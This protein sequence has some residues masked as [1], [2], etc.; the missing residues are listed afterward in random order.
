MKNY[1]E[2]IKTATNT[3]RTPNFIITQ[4]IKIT[5][6][7]NENNEVISSDTFYRRNKWR[8]KQYEYLFRNR[9]SINGKRMQCTMHS[10]IFV[11]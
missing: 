8:D 5:S 10:R 2:K 6:D 1:L 3:Y 4:D 9:K 7:F 11:D